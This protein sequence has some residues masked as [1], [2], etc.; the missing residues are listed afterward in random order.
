LLALVAKGIDD[1]A[2]VLPVWQGPLSAALWGSLVSGIGRVI[3]VVFGDHPNKW[4]LSFHTVALCLFFSI[5][6][7]GV[8]VGYLST[9]LGDAF[10]GVL[11]PF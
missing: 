1:D 3:Y 7:M 6:F 2:S 8:L 11:W 4:G 10:L 9:R 5:Y